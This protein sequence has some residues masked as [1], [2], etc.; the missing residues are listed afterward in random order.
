M[1]VAHQRHEYAGVDRAGPVPMTNPP[2]VEK[3][4]VVATLRPSRMAH[5]RRPIRDAR[6]QQALRQRLSGETG[7]ASTTC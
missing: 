5:M 2:A 7:R 1:I 6:Q 4:M 3:P